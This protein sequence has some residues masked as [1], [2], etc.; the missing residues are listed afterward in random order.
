MFQKLKESRGAWLAA[1]L[2]GGI[3]LSSL[4]GDAWHTPLHATATDRHENFALATGWM[5][6]DVEAV[7]F[8]DFLTGTLRGYVLNVRAGQFTAYYEQNVMADLQVDPQKNPRFL[9]VTGGANI[10]RGPGGVGFGT[11][12]IYVAEATSGNLAAYAVPWVPGAATR[13]AVG[14]SAMKLLQVIPL[15]GNVVRE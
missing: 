1:G 15:R 2:A 14:M 12:V 8:L 5:D 3:L 6:D 11:N 9:I 7:Y 4:M 10:L 13:P